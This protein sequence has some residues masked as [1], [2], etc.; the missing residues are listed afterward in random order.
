MLDIGDDLDYLDEDI[1][2]EPITGDDLYKSLLKDFDS[3]PVVIARGV[4]LEIQQ[5]FILNLETNNSKQFSLPLY[6]YYPGEPLSEFG[7]IKI[8]GSNLLVYKRLGIELLLFKSSEDYLDLLTLENIK[9]TIR[10]EG[11]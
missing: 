5:K 7:T 6:L 8:S 1:S 3:F 11:D 2:L 4:D 10:F 9:N